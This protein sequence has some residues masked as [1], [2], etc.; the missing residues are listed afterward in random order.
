MSEASYDVVIIGGGPAGLMAAWQLRDLNILLVE[1]THR[2]GGRLFSL[3]RDDMWLNFGGHLFPAPGSYMRNLMLEIGLETIPIPGNK[4]ALWHQGKVVAP[5]SVSA[6]PLTLPLSLFERIAL[7]RVGLKIKA[8]VRH[9]QQATQPLAGE[10][11][12]NRRARTARFMSDHSFRAFLGPM[13]AR[14]ES[15]FRAAGQRSAAELED[16]SAGVGLTLFGMVWA[17]KGDSMAVN[18]MGGSGRLG[19][20]MTERLGD[21]ALVEATATSLEP[22]GRQTAVTFERGGRQETVSASQVIVAIPAFAASRIASSL[23]EPVRATLANVRYGPFPSM[24]V[25]TNET[26][27]MP[28]DDIY[29]ITVPG[30]T[31]NMMFNHSNP[32]RALG[33]AKRGSSFMVYSGGKP[34]AEMM[35]LTEDEIRERYLSDIFQLYPEIRPLIVETKVQK[36][37]PGNTYRPAG[38]DFGPVVRYSDRTDTDIHLAG[39][40]FSEIGNME[41]AA[42]TGYEAAQRARRR[43]ATLGGQQRAA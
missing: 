3:P 4:F 37:S 40:Y 13:P 17:G 22:R 21:R 15:L 25:R 10:S 5:A 28:W 2:L 24:A 23:P 19:E 6:L 32:L 11:S 41:T 35:R 20:V 26:K 16:I 14:I 33:G 29:A 31:I 34:A 36:W 9:W 18:M 30:R 38:F 42:G 12:E 43:L 1:R 39:D 27:P 7:A 8:G